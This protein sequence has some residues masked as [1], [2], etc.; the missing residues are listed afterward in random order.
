MDDDGLIEI[1]FEAE[2]IHWRGPSPF[3]FV[4]VPP[5]HVT[6][7]R[8]AARAVSYGWGMVPVAVTIG[9][10]AFRTA[11]FPK[12]DGYLLPLRDAVRRQAQIGLGDTVALAL[13]IGAGDDL[14]SS[15]R[16]G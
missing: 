14:S 7:I 1:A 4:A 16:N 12:D 15:W 13:T 11:L 9:S 2:V 6:P 5:S 3:F 10:V 8:E